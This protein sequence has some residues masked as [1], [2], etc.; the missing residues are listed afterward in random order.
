MGPKTYYKSVLDG[1][2]VYLIDGA[3]F[4]DKADTDFALGGHYYAYPG[5]IPEDEIWL[6]DIMTSDDER[7]L[8]LIHEVVE[9][10]LM[11]YYGHTYESAHT[12]ANKVEHVER[13]IPT[14]HSLEEIVGAL[15]RKLGPTSLL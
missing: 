13:N 12:V 4:R 9:H 6:E 5:I 11:K 7:D 2:K 1:L 8:I 3:I 14:P 10:I 15:H